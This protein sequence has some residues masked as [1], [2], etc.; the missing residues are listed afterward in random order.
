MAAALQR[1]NRKK[2]LQFAQLESD[3][4]Y[5]SHQTFEFNRNVLSQES[6]FLTLLLLRES[7]KVTRVT[8]LTRLTHTANLYRMIRSCGGGLG[9]SCRLNELCVF[10]RPLRSL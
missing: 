4:F 2:D 9:L 8:K 1:M 5:S 3:F 6:F 10:R 7:G